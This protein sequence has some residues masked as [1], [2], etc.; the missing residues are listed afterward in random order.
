MS[1]LVLCGYFSLNFF[2]EKV[3]INDS[4]HIGWLVRFFSEIPF[5]WLTFLLFLLALLFPLRHLGPQCLISLGWKETQRKWGKKKKRQMSSWFAEKSLGKWPNATIKIE[6]W[7]LCICKEN[8]KCHFNTQSAFLLALCLITRTG[9]SVSYRQYLV[10]QCSA[11]IL[12]GYLL[13]QTMSN[14]FCLRFFLEL[15]DMNNCLNEGYSC[16]YIN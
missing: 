10:P 13:Q 1:S 9:L 11:S 2:H 15:Q 4:V 7:W 3:W 6:F 5:S 16:Y 12:E 8:R 14:L